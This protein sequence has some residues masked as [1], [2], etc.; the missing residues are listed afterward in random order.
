LIAENLKLA[1][2]VSPTPVA[3]PFFGVRNR[4]KPPFFLWFTGTLIKVTVARVGKPPKI[5]N[6][7]KTA[8]KI[9]CFENK[10]YRK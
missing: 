6:Y 2:T 7:Q 3:G 9:I 10:N 8:K 4:R 5:N 1:V